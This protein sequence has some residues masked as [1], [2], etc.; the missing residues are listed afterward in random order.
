MP[1][2]AADPSVAP[3]VH[4]DCVNAPRI[5][6]DG[7]EELCHLVTDEDP[8][9]ALCG[10]DVT[11]YPGTRPGR[12]RGL[13]RGFAQRD[14]LGPDGPCTQTR[15]CASSRSRRAAATSTNTT[16]SSARS[17]STGSSPPRSCTR[18]NTDTSPRRSR[19][20][21]DP[22]DVLVC[23]SEPTFPGCVVETK[24]IGLF[25]MA[26]EKGPD[27]HVVCVPWN[28]PGWNTLDDIDDLPEQLRKEIGHFFEIYK[29]L[30]PDR[31]SEVM[32]WDNRQAAFET[33]EK[34]PRAFRENGGVRPSRAGG[35]PQVFH[36]ELR[37]FPH[38]A[39][40]FNLSREELDA[41]ILGPWV[42]RSPIELQDRRWTS[43]KAKLT[44]LEGAELRPDEI[45]LGRGWNNATK[46]GRDVTA[47]V[48]EE[49]AR[50]AGR[51]RPTSSRRRSSPPA[52]ARPI[53]LAQVVAVAAAREPQRRPSELLGAAEQAR[54]GAAARR[55]TAAAAPR[56]RGAT[57]AV[58]AGAA[59]V[60]ELDRRRRD[61]RGDRLLGERSQATT[62]SI[63]RSRSACDANR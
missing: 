4:P 39:R 26:D 3:N 9:T 57:R 24:V 56:R 23:V 59:V 62:F 40:A 2:R 15:S 55:S 52:R 10:K 27:D 47:K 42:Q 13:P 16:P 12:M 54:L 63:I 34:A 48:L 14:E 32:G 22:L 19:T 17:S 36:V 51:R 38:Q 53:A 7:F 6:D 50:H 61:R 41:R 29:D 49:A 18:P 30:D 37:Q 33:I 8:D 11:G 43:D 45:G 35:P 25:K 5:S 28:D 44:I 58:A 20:D 21:G 46:S 60:V 31:R 1:T